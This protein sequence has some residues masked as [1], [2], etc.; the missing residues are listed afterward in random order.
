S[1][2]CYSLRNCL[3]SILYLTWYLV[4]CL[5]LPDF[6]KLTG[7]DGWLCLQTKSEDVNSFMKKPVAKHE[8]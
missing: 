2:R 8:N 4:Y 3:T 6:K 5:N 1:G 7:L